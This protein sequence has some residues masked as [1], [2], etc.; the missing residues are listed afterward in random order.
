MA[1]GGV[2]VVLV[3]NGTPVVLG[4]R[5]T[6]ITIV[7]SGGGAGAPA[8]V[9]NGATVPLT[10]PDG[11]RAFGNGTAVVS[12]GSVQRVSLPG[13]A[14]VITNQSESVNV[15]DAD[16]TT[17]G[18]TPTIVPETGFL[19]FIGVPG[20]AALV[21]NNMSV[22]MASFG[23]AGPVN[24]LM[25]ISGGFI[26]WVSLANQTDVI[27]SNGFSTDLNATIGVSQAGDDYVVA[28]VSAGGL[29][30]VTVNLVP[31]KTVVTHDVPLTVPVTG[32]YTNTVTPTVVNGV[33][34]GITLS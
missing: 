6:P 3:D 23:G 9:S 7:G 8:I 13:T 33:V 11:S 20:T 10:G 34:T 2:P 18:C 26:N 5:G 27:V 25:N 1:K 28:N 12:N 19:S 17:V 32:T 15:T 14:T 30:S 31:T 21:T 16:G 22:K 29:Q 4:N 24:G